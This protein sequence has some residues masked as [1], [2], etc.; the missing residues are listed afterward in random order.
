[1]RQAHPST[2]DSFPAHSRPGH[3]MLHK[4]LIT[5]IAL[6][7]GGW[8]TVDGTHCLL[9]GKYIGPEK[10]GPWSIPFVAA[11]ITPFRL[12][13]VLVVLGAAWIAGTIFLLSAPPPLARSAWITA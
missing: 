8:M 10:P 4:L 7:A 5:A 3:P 6:L 12:A 1:M 9:C 11:G 2:T 13:P